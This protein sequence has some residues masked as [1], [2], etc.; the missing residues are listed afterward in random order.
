MK[1][2]W[3]GHSCFLL[4]ESTGTAIVTDPYDQKLTGFKMP[5]VKADVI[6]CSHNHADHNYVKGVKGAQKII[7]SPGLYEYKGVNITTIPSFHDSRLGKLRGTNLIFKFR[8]DGIDVCHLGD[9]GQDITPE[10]IDAIMPVNILLVPIGGTYTIDAEQA[11]EY[12]STLMP[13]IAIPMHYKT[14]DCKLDIDRLDSFLRFFEESAIMFA[15]E[16]VL[17]FE[18]DDFEQNFT[19]I[20]IPKR[21]Q[22]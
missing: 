18:R 4:E 12:V 5:E 2:Q 16:D 7:N 17:T 15:E 3:L 10:L 21:F 20:I 19:K 6:T 9:I 1:L 14:F 8:I 22:L 13:D 11:Y